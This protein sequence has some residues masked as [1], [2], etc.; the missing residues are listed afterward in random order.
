MTMQSALHT[1]VLAE[2]TEW[3]E[4]VRDRGIGSQVV[5]VPAPRGW[6]RSSLL[7]AFL[8]AADDPD[9]PV[10]FIVCI[11]NFDNAAADVEAEDRAT[12]T[13]SVTPAPAGGQAVQAYALRHAL[14]TPFGRPGVAG[15]LGLDT[16][17]G[18]AQLGVGVGGL[19]ASGL[20][21]AAPLLV[22]S[23]AVTAAGNAWDSSPAGH[24][25]ALAVIARAIARLSLS[26]PVAVVV[27]DADSLDPS[28]AVTMIENLAGR[29][30][31]QVLV[32]AAVRPGSELQTALS[33]PA[34][35]DLLGR[36]HRADL[37]PDMSYGRRAALTR[38]LTPS[39]P[40]RVIE[41]IASRTRTFA[42]VFV[43]GT[44][45]GLAEL[46]SEDDP[47]SATR[48]DAVIDAALLRREV[49]PEATALAWAGGALTVR[50]ADRALQVLDAVTADHDPWVLRS[51][52]LAR[53][54]GPQATI[55]DR[56]VEALAPSDRH[57]MATVVLDETAIMAARTD[58]TL[59]DLVVAGQAAH[60]VRGDLD[61]RAG[62]TATQC[63]LIRGLE[64][65]GDR[66]SAYQVAW[67]ALAELPDSDPSAAERRELCTALLRLAHTQPGPREDPLIA[68][69]VAQA[70]ANGALYGLEAQVW[71]AVKLLSGSGQRD[72]ALQLTSQ[73]TSDLAEQPGTDETANHLRLL[74]AFHAGQAGHPGISQRLLART[75]S[76]G[77]IGQQEAA[78]A[79][80][81]AIGGRR[82]DTRLQVI[83]LEAELGAAQHGVDAELLRLHSV[84]AADYATLGS[85]PSALEHGKRE[86]DLRLR[87]QGADNRH[88]LSA[89]HRIAMWTGECGDSAQAVRLL[90]GLLP[91]HVRVLGPNSPEVLGTRANIA[92]WT[93]QRGNLPQA[94]RLYQKLR[95]DQVRVLGRDHPDVLSTR[96]NIAT[97]TGLC[98]DTARAMRLLMELLPDQERVLGPDHPNTLKT[99]ASIASFSGRCGDSVQALRLHTELLPDRIRVLGPDHPD[100]LGT[101]NSIAVWTGECGDSAEALRLLSDLL[102]DRI[103]VLGPDHPNVLSTRNSI[104]V[105]TGRCGNSAE[106]L[107]LLTDLL[108]DQEGVLGA[109][110]PEVLA[111]RQA[112]ASLR[113]RLHEAPE[114]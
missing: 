33:A 17:A 7:N 32:V 68:E 58:A 53:L 94:L 59:I 40:D 50:Q 64:K 90:T 92:L 23:L 35:H 89:R 20:A 25:G 55:L 38:Q 43:V 65:L 102:P 48:V 81:Y 41:R 11:G 72:A 111:T 49:T 18:K 76:A 109:D 36:V 4:N 37:D 99:R 56:H 63:A 12:S 88:T 77:T 83:V 74:L 46:A 42:D 60:H 82:A 96:A 93:G 85:Y 54:A 101:R 95:P 5:L 91:D 87:L 113:K 112:M 73:V 66:A 9:G 98:G 21:V 62:L 104:A 15:L 103:R 100:V 75:I 84:L 47:G 45:R 24:Q 107:R 34:R 29:I 69:A 2:L 86:L 80:L 44:A 22:A 57:R 19:F 105:W 61:D 39:L 78:Q 30:D 6:G 110:H 31:G 79:V 51:G 108:P 106:A 10:T 8:R 114:P 27:D 52:G 97:L 14:M 16:V 13:V 71:A 26:A 1:P 28:L 70:A 3:W 67:A